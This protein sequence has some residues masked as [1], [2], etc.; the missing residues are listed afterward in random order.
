RSIA[1]VIQVV[2]HI[3][4][5]EGHRVVA[6]V[7]QVR[8][9]DA[10]RDAYR[11]ADWKE[12]PWTTKRRRKEDTSHLR[13]RTARGL[14]RWRRRA[15]GSSGTGSW[16]SIFGKTTNGRTDLPSGRSNASRA[17]APARSK[18]YLATAEEIASPDF[19]SRL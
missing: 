11:V 8:G 15:S 7:I 19:Q 3:E 16:T 2:A 12:E 10:A 14:R 1:E 17:G 18:Q 6:E 5:R 4:R 9:Y 13:I